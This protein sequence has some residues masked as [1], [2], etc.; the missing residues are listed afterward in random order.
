MGV[1]G[2]KMY[3]WGG[4]VYEPIERPAFH[5]IMYDIMANK[6]EVPDADLVKL[7]DVYSDC[8]N[9]V[10]SKQLYVRNNI[11]IFKNGVLDVEEG[12]FYKRFD[13]RFVQMWAVDYDYVPGAR[14]FLW[15]QFINQVLPD[16]FWQDALQMFLGATFLDRKKVKIEH[17]LILLGRG[18]NGKV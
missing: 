17:I 2:G 6:I 13:P 10:Y 9:I 5:S 4:K 18:A 8:C 14:T 3:Y 7:S 1:F 12:K 11:M 16:T 15:H